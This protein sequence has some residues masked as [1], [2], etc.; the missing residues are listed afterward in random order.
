VPKKAYINLFDNAHKC[1]RGEVMS[2]EKGQ[3]AV[4]DFRMGGGIETLIQ[5]RAEV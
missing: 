2:P 5:Y 3:Y 1:L 4:C